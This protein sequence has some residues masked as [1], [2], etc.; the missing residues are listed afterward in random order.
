MK[1]VEY[2]SETPY[3]RTAAAAA[4]SPQSIVEYEGTYDVISVEE[5]T[6]QTIV[7]AASEQ[8]KIVLEFEALENGYRYRQQDRH[9]PYKRMETTIRLVDDDPTTVDI[10]SQFEFGGTLAFLKN[11]IGLT[12]RRREIER[13]AS[14]LLY[15]VAESA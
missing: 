6:A 7:R 13:L 10:V 1:I 4:L 11:W 12:F 3:S 5:K 15:A 9:G 14:N 8:L 2:T